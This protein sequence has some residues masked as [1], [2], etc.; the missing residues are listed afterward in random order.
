MRKLLKFKT[1]IILLIFIHTNSY[2]NISLPN[3]IGSN[4]VLQSNARVKIWG[5]AEPG[6]KISVTFRGQKDT[7]IA[8]SSSNWSV[9]L[10]PFTSDNF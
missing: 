10:K 6:E 1:I 5:K 2:A 3:I 7:T 4:M 9:Y 8:D